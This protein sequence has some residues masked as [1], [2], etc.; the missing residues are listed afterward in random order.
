MNDSASKQYYINVSKLSFE[1]FHCLSFRDNKNDENNIHANRVVQS[2]SLSTKDFVD[3][4]DMSL[5]EELVPCLIL[6]FGVPGCCFTI[7]VLV[8]VIGYLLGSYTVAWTITFTILLL[9]TVIPVHLSHDVLRSWVSFQCLRYFSY[10]I[11]YEEICQPNKAYILVAPP[12]GVFAIG[13]L[14][15]LL[16][17]PYVFGFS[18]RALGTSIALWIPIFRNILTSIGVID[19]SRSTATKA[20]KELKNV[21][22]STGGVAEVFDNNNGF[23]DEV[24]VLKERK[25]L[26]KLAFRTGAAITP[27]YVFGNT[28]IYSSWCWGE[29]GDWLHDSFR[30]LA[31]KIGFAPITFWGRFYLPLPYRKP[32][33]FV[34]GKSIAV[35]QN[36]NPA[37]E[38]VD[39]IHQLL[40]ERMI[41][42]FDRYK[43]LYGWSHKKLIIK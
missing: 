9:L 10:K 23:G 28:Q 20:L 34:I 8:T 21:G 18:S 1:E 22:I 5:L 19:A 32:I 37:D 3:V 6:L 24:I 26:V 12:H 31:R 4:V 2:N 15:S 35:E 39:R 13:N 36:D 41:D 40:Q 25:G 42:L 17:C 7:P 29:R 16:A 27:S 30:A 33:V 14:L 38:E 11:V 43:G